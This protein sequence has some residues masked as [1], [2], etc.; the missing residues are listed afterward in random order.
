MTTPSTPV[1]PHALR[2]AAVIV[3]TVAG[4]VMARV[5]WNNARRRQEERRGF[6][7]GT[8][9]PPKGGNLH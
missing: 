2:V 9:K 1:S 7:V 5:E 6:E 4:L 8:K 3:F